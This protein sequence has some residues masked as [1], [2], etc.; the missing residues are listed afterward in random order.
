MKEDITAM[1]EDIKEK[2]KVGAD[3]ASIYLVGHVPR[4]PLM[5]GT[6]CLSRCSV[7]SLVLA[8]RLS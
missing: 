2:E 1:K 3:H 7:A 5:M 4:P 6:S 8:R